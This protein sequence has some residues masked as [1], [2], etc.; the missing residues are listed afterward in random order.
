V[1]VQKRHL[2]LDFSV[3][4]RFRILEIFHIFLRFESAVR[5]EIGHNPPSLDEHPHRQHT[6]SNPVEKH[7]NTFL[8]EKPGC[9]ETGSRSLKR[10]GE[11]P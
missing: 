7:S 9:R 2:A 5:L 10:N 4:R 1:S 8:R 3:G 11:P 6:I